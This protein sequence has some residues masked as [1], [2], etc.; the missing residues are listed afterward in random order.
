MMNIP[1]VR[2]FEMDVLISKPFLAPNVPDDLTGNVGDQQKM[3]WIRSQLVEER[4]YRFLVQDREK[5][6]WVG[7]GVERLDLLVQPDQPQ[8]VA[9]FEVAYLQPTSTRWTPLVA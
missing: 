7:L 9:L 4:P 6:L 3:M 1:G 8:R 2:R 5:H